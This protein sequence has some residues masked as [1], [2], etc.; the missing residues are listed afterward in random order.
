VTA[1][2]IGMELETSLRVAAH[3]NSVRAVRPSY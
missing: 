2:Q 1:P 3:G